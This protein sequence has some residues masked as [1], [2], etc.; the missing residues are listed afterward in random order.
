MNSKYLTRSKGRKTIKSSHEA[1]KVMLG[2]S[3]LFN[4]LYLLH[5]LV[6]IRGREKSHK[7]LGMIKEDIN[8]IMNNNPLL[9]VIQTES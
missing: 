5:G 1:S 6:S 9:S 7:I 3:L 2:Q 4:L 8:V